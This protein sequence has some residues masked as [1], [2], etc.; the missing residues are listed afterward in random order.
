MRCPH[1][2][3]DVPSLLS[4]GVPA[5]LLGM[6]CVCTVCA[7]QRHAHGNRP[8]ANVLP[9]ANGPCVFVSWPCAAKEV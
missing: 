9:C 7:C 6:H 5:L 1:V 8:C 4:R 2:L 3:S